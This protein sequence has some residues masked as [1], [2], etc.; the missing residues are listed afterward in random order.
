M[1]TFIN[2]KKYSTSQINVIGGEK[3]LYE[4]S[5]EVYQ[6]A[7]MSAR[8]CIARATASTMTFDTVS[9]YMFYPMFICLG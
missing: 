1:L 2:N 9:E 3:L 8:I 4:E 5:A 7:N 6:V